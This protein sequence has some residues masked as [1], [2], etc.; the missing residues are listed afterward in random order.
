[1]QASLDLN[2]STCTDNFILEGSTS[3][4]ET[5]HLRKRKACGKLK[6]IT[7]HNG[8]ERNI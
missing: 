4:T 7:N 5:N 2:D 6:T 3:N 8:F 1:M